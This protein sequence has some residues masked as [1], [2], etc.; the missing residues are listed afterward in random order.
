MSNTTKNSVE[1]AKKHLESSVGVQRRMKS[2]NNLAQ[3]Y[4]MDKEESGLE[5]TGGK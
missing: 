4:F 3:L 2:G 5:P 1:S